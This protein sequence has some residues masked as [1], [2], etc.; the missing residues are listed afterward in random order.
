MQ[1]SLDVDTQKISPWKKM[2]LA[3]GGAISASPLLLV[4]TSFTPVSQRLSGAGLGGHHP[5]LPQ[6][7]M[8]L[9]FLIGIVMLVSR[10]I[11]K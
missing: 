2:S 11:C 6:E 3:I 1:R 7:L 4:W 10:V 8:P 9:V 5:I